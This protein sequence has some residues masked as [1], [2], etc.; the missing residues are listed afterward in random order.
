MSLLSHY[1]VVSSGRKVPYELVLPF[2]R[3]LQGLTEQEQHDKMSEFAQNVIFSCPIVDLRRL[4]A[5]IDPE[6]LPDDE[7]LL[8]AL[9]ERRIPLHT[10]LAFTDYI[11]NH[12]DDKSRPM[13]DRLAEEIEHSYRLKKVFAE[14]HKRQEGQTEAE[15]QRLELETILTCEAAA[16]AAADEGEK[17]A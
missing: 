5:I 13:R 12:T 4:S 15:K 9:R 7:P 1:R 6:S 8:R 16:E 14:L 2:V 11:A 10:L 17:G 3:S